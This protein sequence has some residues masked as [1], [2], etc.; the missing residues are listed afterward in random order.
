VR[1]YTVFVYTEIVKNV[2]LSAEADLIERARIRAA[3]ER[4]TLN[5]AFR[6]W[7]RSYAGAGMTRADYFD[8]MKRLGHVRTT[9]SFSRDERNDRGA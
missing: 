2:T 5:T 3:S 6:E 7:L 8:L 1:G 9:R 4:T